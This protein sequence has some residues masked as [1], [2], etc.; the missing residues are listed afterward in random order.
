MNAEQ[1]AQDWMDQCCQTIKQY[2]HNAHMDLIS[3]DV[4]VLGV[5]GYDVIAYSDWYSQCEYEFREKL[6]AETSYQGLKICHSDE[7]KVMFLT[8]ETVK[9]TDGTV[10]SHPIEVLLSQEEDGVWR[11]TR[12]RLLGRDEAIQ[13]GIA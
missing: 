7:Q 1:I 13:L 3:Q 9:T 2:D 12:E 8:N 6:I 10:D 5:P 11:V 4:E